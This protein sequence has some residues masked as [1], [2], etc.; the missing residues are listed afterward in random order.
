MSGR[1]VNQ[2]IACIRTSFM[3]RPNAEVIRHGEKNLEP[4]GVRRP[5][6]K[7]R[8]PDEFH[9]GVDR[10]VSKLSH[11]LPISLRTARPFANG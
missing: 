9:E 10:N 1:S 7:N 2:A 6:Q 5:Q 8:L 4:H 11:E 3:S